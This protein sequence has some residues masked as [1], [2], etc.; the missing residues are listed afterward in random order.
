MANNVDK[1]RVSMNLRKKDCR[2]L[3]EVNK[4]GVSFVTIG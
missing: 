3:F 2:G 1:V 4:M